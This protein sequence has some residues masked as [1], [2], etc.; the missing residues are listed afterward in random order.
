MGFSF[1]IVDIH[2]RESQGNL[3][4]L[5]SGFVEKQIAAVNP[6]EMM[7][8]KMRV[9]KTLFI[10]NNHHHR[11]GW[12]GFSGT[13]EKQHGRKGQQSKGGTD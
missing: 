2:P 7:V 10:A 1:Q 9:E 4:R 11:Q 5:I 8:G 3:L 13:L 6:G 12:R